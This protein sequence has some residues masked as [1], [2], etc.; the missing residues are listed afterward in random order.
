M[1][2]PLGANA[3]RTLAARGISGLLA[4]ALV[5]VL[6]VLGGAGA[7]R[8]KP[9]VTTVLPA[10]AGLIRPETPVQYRGVRVGRLAAVEPGLSGSRLTLR[11]EPDSFADVPGDVRVRLMPRT[12][13]GDQYLDLVTSATSA[14]TALA[15]GAQLAADDSHPT[16]QLYH[17]YNRLY[18]LVDSLQPAQLQVSLSALAEAM[19]GRGEQLGELIDDSAQLTADPPLTGDD[20]ADL[21]ALADDIAAAAPDAARALD[22]AVALSGP[23][24]QRRQDI[25]DL[26][27]AGLAFTS[28]S[29]RFVDENSERIIQLVRS[30]EP[31]A[32]V[33]GRHPGAIREGVNGLD[34]FLDG[35]NRSLSTGFFKIRLSGTLHRPYP[36]GPEDCPR[37][38]GMDGPNCHDARPRGPIGPVGGQQERDVLREL[39]PLLPGS[40]PAPDALGLLL[41]P[42]VR[43]TEV[44][45]P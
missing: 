28:Q 17:A 42:V 32:D 8:S 26:L 30:G 15:P 9:E 33:L 6:I 4:L 27:G 41:G 40:P 34:T 23:V 16:M 31:V 12:V 1:T 19:R 10:E 7:L 20:L 21:A 35:A 18:D 44:V 25:G 3:R 37:Y 2:E 22:D 5:A 43:G 45:T 11:M 29:Q 36:Y 38:P 14:S 24:V 13:F 39:A